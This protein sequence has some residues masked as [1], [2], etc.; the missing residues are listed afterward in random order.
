MTS[1]GAVGSQ[2][3]ARMALAEVR[4]AEARLEAA[5]R[6]EERAARRRESAEDD[7]R[8]AGRRAGRVD[9]YA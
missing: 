1:T 4:A 5:R 6:D 9:R 3:G 8:A 2:S 7:V